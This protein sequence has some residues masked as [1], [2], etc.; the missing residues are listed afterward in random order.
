[1]KMNYGNL[2]HACCFGQ[3]CPFKVYCD[4]DSSPHV[5]LYGSCFNPWWWFMLQPIE[6][7]VKM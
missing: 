5:Y 1:M 7:A 3:K 4:L 2:H 6:S